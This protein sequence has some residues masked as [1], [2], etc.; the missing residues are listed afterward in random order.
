MS[1]GKRQTAN[2][3]TLQQP[4]QPRPTAP[5]VNAP[6]PQDQP[7]NTTRQPQATA[8]LRRA[9]RIADRL[10]AEAE[11]CAKLAAQPVRH[12]H[13]AGIDVGDASHWVCVDATPD[14]S[15]TV[16]EFPA[17]TP[18]LRQLVAWLMQCGVPSIALEATGV[19]GHSLYLTLLEAGFAVITAPP[20]FA[21][22]IKGRPK[23]DK[24]DCQWIQR[25]HKLGLLPSIFQPNEATHALRDYV[26][27]RA[28][29]V[30]LSSQHI[31][32]MQK[33]LE[34]MNLKLTK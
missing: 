8:D 23:T 17:H 7:H 27:Q 10:R 5:I 14:G 20:Q 29:L 31:Q 32:R 16:R 25:L 6:P 18:G 4:L 3:R 19:Y 34:S 26:R 9:A 12:E 33:A 11:A 28:N 2:A 22:Q 1:V 30:R 24:R 21:R 13:A 15:D